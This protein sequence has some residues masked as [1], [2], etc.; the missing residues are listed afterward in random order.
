MPFIAKIRTTGERLPI[1]DYERILALD[2]SLIVCPF[3]EGAMFIRGG[4]RTA[5]RRHFAHRSEC[6]ATWLPE[7]YTS[8]LETAEHL[9]GKEWLK[10]NFRDLL[11]DEY[12]KGATAEY[13]MVVDVPADGTRP[14]RRRVADVLVTFPDGRL[15]ALECQLASITPD[16]LAERTYDYQRAGI[17][18]RWV[19]GKTA[20]RTQNQDWCEEHF[21]V[22]Y[23][24]DFSYAAHRTAP[25]QR[26]TAMPMGQGEQDVATYR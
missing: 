21:G 13:E 26:L 8:G 4:D 12:I 23:S 1:F 20:D 16:V 25:A 19:L 17:D 11:G 7:E 14:A 3:C 6:G 18:V 10:L 24:F 15:I 2:K 9:A 5:Y 22:S